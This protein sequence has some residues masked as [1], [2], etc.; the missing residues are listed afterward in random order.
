MNWIEFVCLKETVTVEGNHKCK[1]VK[2]CTVVS[3]VSSFVGNPVH[4][5]CIKVHNTGMEVK[6]LT[7]HNIK[8]LTAVKLQL[9]H[10][11]G[12]KLQLSHIP[13]LKLHSPRR[14]SSIHGCIL[15][16][17]NLQ[18]YLQYICKLP[19]FI[20]NPYLIKTFFFIVLR[21]LK[22]HKCT[23]IYIFHGF[24]LYIK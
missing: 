17:S 7:H 9:S 24:G 23:Y 8:N 12:L 19:T 16:F 18:I 5:K 3:E 14:L 13:G 15:T 2:F 20:A 11:P 6:C 4:C 1:A 21:S 22:V 10:I